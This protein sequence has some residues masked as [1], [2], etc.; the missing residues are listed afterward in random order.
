VIRQRRD[1]PGPGGWPTWYVD[2]ADP[3]DWSGEAHG[4][5]VGDSSG[6]DPDVASA[7][8]PPADAG[9]T[10]G[11]GGPRWTA[12]KVDELRQAAADRV[13]PTLRG[14][15]PVVSVRAALAVTVIAA[16]ALVVAFGM[17]TSPDRQTVPARTS[18]RSGVRAGA[19]PAGAAGSAGAG[20][21]GAGSVST[22]MSSSAASPGPTVLVVDVAGRVQHPGLVRLPPGSRV[23]D[24]V[25]AAGGSTSLA[26]LDRLNLARPLTDGEQ[27]LVPGADDPLPPVAAGSVGGTSLAGSGS[28]AV[29]D[30]NTATETQLDGLPGVGPV[31]AGRIVT[32]RTAHGRFSRVEELSEVTGIGE[33]LFAQLRP[34]VR[35]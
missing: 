19:G 18:T 25:V 17:L 22:W 21:T 2:T 23:W 14:R 34:L 6:E 32:W 28:A 5:E 9:A 16:L 15:G 7:D 1:D 13:P 4:D 26:R 33:K 30:L 11:T 12:A 29:I 27:V 10:R 24:A 35:V 31:L 3:G 20:S 8:L